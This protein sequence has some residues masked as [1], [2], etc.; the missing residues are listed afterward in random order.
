VR[1]CS[2]TSPAGGSPRLGLVG[3]D[4]A[5]GPRVLD[6]GAWARSRDAE[7]PADLVDLVLASAATQERVADLARS[8]PEGAPG[9][10]RPEEVRL[11]A[12]LRSAHAVRSLVAWGSPPDLAAA[13]RSALLGPVDD[14]PWPSYAGA[15]AVAPSVGAVVGRAGRDLD[16]PL[17]HVFGWLLLAPWTVVGVAG[18]KARVVTSLGGVVVTPDEL[19]PAGLTATAAV[20]GLP[21]AV[22]VAAGVGL[23]EVVRA[24]SSA[25]ELQPTEVVG[26]A[27]LTEPVPVGRG[28][29][30]ELRVPGL[31]EVVARVG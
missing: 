17:P 23:L 4:A 12:P 30:V 24:A 10:V 14:V 20:D 11:L 19:D 6:V 9:W 1:W 22:P 15:L 31:G 27:G 16:D 21:A 8:A 25:E 28:S 18:A 26:G 2:F 29:A 7:A 3:P 5:S 13:N